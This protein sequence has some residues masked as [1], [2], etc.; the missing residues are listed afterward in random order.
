MSGAQSGHGVLAVRYGERA[1]TRSEVYYRWASYGE[2]DGPL[3]MTYWFWVIEPQAGPPVVV[4]CGFAPELGIRMGRTCTC[5][6]AEALARLGI[7]GAGVEEL[8]ITHLHYDHIGNLELFPHATFVVARRELEFWTG[9][10]ATRAHFAAHTDPAAVAVLAQAAADGRVRF[11]DD[12]LTVAP[13]IEAI[14]VGGHSPGQL[15][16]LVGARGGDVLL[17]SDAVHYEEEL[18][19]E[20]PF[21]VLADLAEV[22]RAYDTVRELVAAGARLVPGHDPLVAEQH[23]ALDDGRDAPA[24]R[25]A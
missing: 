14:R 20:R 21:A 2:P 10:I 4:D 19:T 8:V 15:V 5:P 1:T 9:P 24:V 7:D 17:A 12:E 25:I 23:P 6:P 22:Y 13:G 3:G 16:V 18:E 11:V